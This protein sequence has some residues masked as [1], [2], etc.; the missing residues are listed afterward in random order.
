MKELL[1][2]IV[3]QIVNHP[4]DVLIEENIDGSNINYLLSVNPEDMGM[5]I[6]KKGQTIKAIRKILAIRAMIE[7]VRVN[8]QLNE[9]QG[10]TSVEN[11]ESSD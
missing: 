4:D 8:V 6:G 5:V 7:N 9:P 2:Y 1:D 11:Q 3:K 10:V